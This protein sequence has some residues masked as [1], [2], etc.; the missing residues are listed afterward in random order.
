MP[1]A[2][3]VE[4]VETAEGAVIRV[5]C[6][7]GSVGETAPMSTRR[8]YGPAHR[9][10]A[11][12]PDLSPGRQAPSKRLM[13]R[14]QKQE[15]TLAEDTGG[16]RQKGSGSQAHAKGDVRLRGHFRVE[17]KQTIKNSIGIKRF[18]LDKIRSE[19]DTGESPALDVEFLEKGTLRQEDRWVM[20]PYEDWLDKYAIA[21]DK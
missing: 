6:P 8:L 16:S 19:C 3:D 15:Q 21:T 5:Y 7:D 13:R 11:M 17:S 10:V 2:V 1:L 9:I 20:I 14:S 12:E 4:I 18:W